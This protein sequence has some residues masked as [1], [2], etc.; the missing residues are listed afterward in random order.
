MGGVKANFYKNSK[1]VNL[2]DFTFDINTGV[3]GSVLQAFCFSSDGTKV[4]TLRPNGTASIAQF[5]LS[6]PYD[7]N[8]ISTVE[9]TFSLGYSGGRGIWTNPS[10]NNQIGVWDI[11]YGAKVYNLGTDND[12][13][14]AVLDL[15]NNLLS[16]SIDRGGQFSDDG[17]KFIIS[18]GTETLIYNLTTAY[19]FTTASLSSSGIGITTSR[20]SWIINNGNGCLI[21]SSLSS[22][23][24]I[25]QVELTSPYFIAP[26]LLPNITLDLSSSFGTGAVLTPK[27][28]PD[29]TKLHFMRGDNKIYQFII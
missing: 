10:V 7:I 29:Q 12:I 9:S 14:S 3:L 1:T 23:Q 18:D 6:T 24:R 8:T 22:N 28:T 21:S 15:T 16:S 13:S 5:S 2:S 25:D 17:N 20:G 27:I 11:N 26:G 4:W 19:D